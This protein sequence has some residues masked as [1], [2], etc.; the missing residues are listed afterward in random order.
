MT[1]TRDQF[2]KRF[3]PKQMETV[4][5]YLIQE[6]NVLRS[7]RNG[8]GAGII[9]LIVPQLNVLRAEHNMTEITIDQALTALENDIG[10]LEPLDKD[11]VLDELKDIWDSLPDYDW[12]ED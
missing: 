8:L 9:R 2:Y 5:R 7:E 3:G 10:V 12:M 11:T 4:M 1:I 6:V